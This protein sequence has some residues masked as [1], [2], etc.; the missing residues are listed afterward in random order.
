MNIKPIKYQKIINAI[1]QDIK[2]QYGN[3]FS[4]ELEYEKNYYQLVLEKNF[5]NIVCE[6]GIIRT[7]KFYDYSVIT[8]IHK[9]IIS[10]F[11]MFYLCC[12]EIK[13]KVEL[14]IK[15]VTFLP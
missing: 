14:E 8:S 13:T 5:L 15:V 6:Y 1:N 3:D 7:P 4:F 10:I 9:I 2:E 11:E 12:Y